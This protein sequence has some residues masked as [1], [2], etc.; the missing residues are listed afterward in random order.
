MATRIPESGRRSMTP[1]GSAFAVTYPNFIMLSLRNTTTRLSLITFTN[2]LVA[3]PG[4]H[5]FYQ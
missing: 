3:Q 2:L 5:L 1:S 4:V